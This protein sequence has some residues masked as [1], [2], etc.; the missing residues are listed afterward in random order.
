MADDKKIEIITNISELLEFTDPEDSNRYLIVLDMDDLLIK[1]EHTLGSDTW[2]HHSMKSGRNITD[3]LENMGYAYSLIKY[4]RVEP[5][6]LEVLTELLAPDNIDYIIMT[7]RGIMYYS[8]T[9]K[10]LKDAGLAHLFIRPNMLSFDGADDL[11]VKGVE[12]NPNDPDMYPRLRQVR[13]IDNICFCAGNDKGLILEEIIY[14]TH[15]ANPRRKYK[16]IVFADDSIKNVNIVHNRFIKP[17]RKN[18][19]RGIRTYAIH[20]S[21]LEIQ[22]RRYDS[23]SLQADDKMMRSLQNSI[24][25]INGKAMVNYVLSLYILLGVSTLWWFVFRFLGIITC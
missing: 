13:Y 6:T 7:S 3:V 20:Y 11:I 16:T 8:Q 23:V 17:S 2:F 15:A 9:L 19:L 22:K 18:L 21:F 5:D 1:G 10:H 25:Y 12:P 24:S 4:V 14:R